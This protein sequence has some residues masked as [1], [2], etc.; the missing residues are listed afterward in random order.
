MSEERRGRTRW[1]SSARPSRTGP[2]AWPALADAQ[3]QFL[4]RDDVLQNAGAHDEVVLWFE[5]DLYDQLQLI[6]LLDW[7]AA[8]PH[9]K[10]TL[11]C[12]AEYLGTMTP[13]RA[14]ELFERRRP[15]SRAQL[16]AG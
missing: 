5:H 3:K 2:P 12:E 4:S 15:V 11:V 6:Q 1:M 9:P 10:L 16:R 7:F 14:A 13:A 8:H